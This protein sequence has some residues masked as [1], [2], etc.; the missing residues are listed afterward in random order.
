PPSKK[1]PSEW[2]YS[3]VPVVGP[4]IGGALGGFL[5]AACRTMNDYADWS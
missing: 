5:F 3:W 4:F 2:Y 1:G